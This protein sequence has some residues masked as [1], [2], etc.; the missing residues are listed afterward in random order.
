MVDIVTE[1]DYTRVRAEMLQDRQ[2]SQRVTRGAR[3][4]EQQHARSIASKQPVGPGKR[5][6]PAGDV[7]LGE[8]R[9]AAQTQRRARSDDD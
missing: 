8:D 3:S 6:A 2:R 5:D 4:I 1:Q 7:L 9:L